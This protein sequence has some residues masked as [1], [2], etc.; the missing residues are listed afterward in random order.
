MP[1]LELLRPD[2]DVE[3]WRDGQAQQLGGAE[4]EVGDQQVLGVKL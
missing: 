2:G 3:W 4:V 1:H